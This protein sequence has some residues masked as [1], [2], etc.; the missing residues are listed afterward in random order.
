MTRT[1]T[2]P[3]PNI[4][5]PRAPRQPTERPVSK[6]AQRL[7]GF[8]FGIA[9]GFLLQKGGVAQYDILI[10]SL[11]LTD[12][13]VFKVMLSAILVGMIGIFTMHRMGLAQLH[14]K[15]LKVGANIL[16]GLVFGLGFGIS[17]YCPG[18]GGAAVGQGNYDAVFAMLGLI[19]GSYLYAEF[20]GVLQRTIG[21]WGDRG[22]VMLPDVVSAPRPIVIAGGAAVIV[23][24]LV[25]LERL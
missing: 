11:L 12:F 16:G 9:F 1:N 18:T 6:P 15:P 24:A 7:Q 2:E 17:G 25:I 21:R 23:L 13:T 19:A 14:P 10:G 3:R 4:P 22:K 8:V 20:A 5:P